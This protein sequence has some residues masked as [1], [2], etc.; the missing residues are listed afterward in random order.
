MV[1]VRD[2]IV[3]HNLK[4]RGFMD[5]LILF[6]I[7]KLDKKKKRFVDL[8]NIPEVMIKKTNLV[9]FELYAAVHIAYTL[10]LLE[11]FADIGYRTLKPVKFDNSKKSEFGYIGLAVFKDSIERIL[12]AGV[13]KKDHHNNSNKNN[14][15]ENYE[16]TRN[17]E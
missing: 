4:S 6:Q 5:S 1:K 8:I 10:W 13:S 3:H 14:N 12:A 2:E 17:I 9:D 7:T 11:K 16:T 15:T